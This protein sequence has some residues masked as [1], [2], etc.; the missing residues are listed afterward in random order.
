MGVKIKS[1]VKKINNREPGF[2]PFNFKD[3]YNQILV[4]YYTPHPN[5]GLYNIL[6]FNRV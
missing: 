3:N 5:F 2:I 4:G 6:L 1:I